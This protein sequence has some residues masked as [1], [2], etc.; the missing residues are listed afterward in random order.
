MQQ[1]KNKLGEYKKT[2]AKG[3]IATTDIYNDLHL[4][5]EQQANMTWRVLNNSGSISTKEPGGVSKE[6][7]Y[8]RFTQ[9]GNGDL[10]GDFLEVTMSD[11][12]TSNYKGVKLGKIVLTFSNA[13]HATISTLKNASMWLDIHSNIINGMYYNDMQSFQTTMKLYDKNGNLIELGND[14]SAWIA[15][16]S[17]NALYW[18]DG[19]TRNIEEVRLDSNGTGY[20][21]KGSTVIK[22]S[23]GFWYSDVMII[24][25]FQKID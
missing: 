10:N 19:S 1:Y 14:N 7:S 15:I 12:Q 8:I 5:D 17:L 23:D 13:K 4:Q 24:M 25:V 22:H 21:L 3:E 18:K 2:L 9:N 20:K 11:L 16:K 6:K